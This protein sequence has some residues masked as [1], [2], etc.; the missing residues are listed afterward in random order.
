[1]HFINIVIIIIIIINNHSGILVSDM[2]VP[3]TTASRVLKLRLEDRP[4][5]WKV[6]ANI[7]I[8]QLRTA[9]NGWSSDLGVGGRAN[10]V[11]FIC[12]LT[13]N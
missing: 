5:I 3:V 10:N 7:L 9:V 2:W 8:K 12:T 13:D 4:P 11:S 6:A 1:M